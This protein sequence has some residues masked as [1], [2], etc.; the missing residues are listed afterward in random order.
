MEDLSSRALQ[1]DHLLAVLR[2]SVNILPQII[3]PLQSCCSSPSFPLPSCCLF[4]LL[5]QQTE[6][7]HKQI[8]QAL[9]AAGIR[10]ES[11]FWQ[12]AT[13]AVQHD[14]VSSSSYCFLT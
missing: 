12:Q 4:L 2:R 7:A 3:A 6:G 5:Q 14:S 9:H 13:K 8:K 1:C 10:R 11:P